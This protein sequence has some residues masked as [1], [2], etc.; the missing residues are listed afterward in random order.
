M[1][2]EF[3]L[4]PYMGAI[5][6]K[7]WLVLGVGLLF[8]ILA[9]FVA[10]TR[11]SVYQASA[12]VAVLEPTE[13]VQ[14]DSRFST[15]Q[16]K[17]SLLKAYP[18]LARSDEILQMLLQKVTAPG[19]DRL[20][21]LQSML[22]V[23]AGNEPSLLYFRAHHTDPAIAAELAN[24][25]A[26]L[27]VDTANSIYGLGSQ[28]QLAF[29]EQ[30]LEEAD[31]RLVDSEQLLI[32]FQT[33]NRLTLVSN[34]LDALTQL[35]AGYLTGQN[36]LSVLQDDIAALQEQVDLSPTAIPQL[37]E[38]LTT[39]SLQS[40]AFSIQG[41]LPIVLQVNAEDIAEMNREQ[42]VAFLSSLS[43]TIEERLVTVDQRLQELEPQILELQRSKQ[44]LSTQESTLQRNRD[45][46]AETYTALARKVDEEKITTQD[47]SSGFR[48]ASRASIPVSPSSTSPIVL[49]LIGVAIGAL[50]AALAI[51]LWTWWRH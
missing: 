7:W 14:F 43:Q 51:I 3:D 22:T 16:S 39:L 5:L 8:G 49:S 30:Q 48:L 27:F 34:Q 20:P 24:E 26:S 36:T 47:T 50:L 19:I 15:V 23:Q 40:R 10:A 28:N 46:L 17:T 6:Q 35:Q 45:L 31:Q 42:Q 1:E 37:T 4:R 21:E 29:Y 13:Q 9:Y 38:Q 12:L 32:D 41:T 44:D 33:G 2:E 11:P 18:E 25:W